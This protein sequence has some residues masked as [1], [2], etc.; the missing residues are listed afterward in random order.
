MPIENSFI[1]ARNL[2]Q[3]GLSFIKDRFYALPFVIAALNV[4]ITYSCVMYLFDTSKHIIYYV[5]GLNLVIF[6][7]FAS[8]IIYHIYMLRYTSRVTPYG[9]RFRYRL[10]LL[11]TIA[12]ILPVLLL[13]VFSSI[14]F[15]NAAK[16]WF[17]TKVERAV[18]NA[19]Y[20]ADAYIQEH[21]HNIRAD[22]F[23]TAVDF[24]KAFKVTQS[25]TGLEKNL[26]TQ[27]LLR[28]LSSI[29]VFDN[30]GKKIIHI[31]ALNDSQKKG[32]IQRLMPAHLIKI[33]RQN[34]F[35]YVDTNTY[36]IHA[37]KR[38]L[39]N[40]K[41]VI[42]N[43]MRRVSDKAVRYDHQTKK[44]VSD[45]KIIKSERHKRELGYALIYI[46]FGM[47]IIILMVK[48]GQ[49]FALQMT[50]PLE[51]LTRTARDIEAGNESARYP[52]PTKVRDEIDRLMIAFNK[53]LDT[54]SHEKK[55]TNAVLK[56]VSTGVICLDH[57]YNVS[58]INQRAVDIFKVC[59]KDLHTLIDL[60][61]DFRDFIS[62]L[63]Q[64]DLPQKS[65]EKARD[66]N[67]L[68][69]LNNGDKVHL[70]L[71]YAIHDSPLKMI[72]YIITI[73]DI[74]ELMR[75]QSTAVWQDIAQRIA[76]EIKNPLTPISLATE[77]IARKWGKEI[78]SSPEKFTQTLEIIQTQVSHILDTA[79]ALSELAK[80]PSPVFEKIN[81]MQILHEVVVL[82]KIRS[83]EIN[84][85]ITDIDA[86]YLSGDKRL[87]SQIMINLLKNATEAM[88]E[89]QSE[90]KKI[91]IDINMN[92]DTLS[93]K[94]RD[95]G[96]GLPEDMPQKTLFTPY[97]T[98]K[99]NGT[100]IG[101]AIVE[102][103]MTDHNGTI[104]LANYYDDA[105]E[106]IVGA[107][108]TLNLPLEI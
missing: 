12:A 90:I 24:S 49:Y 67:K 18:H 1:Y 76:H 31:D 16:G 51:M 40:Q 41:Y 108:V 97:V 74:S 86:I 36:Q 52:S 81:I 21:H 53:M 44:A 69:L 77:H 64:L 61:P 2:S 4:V 47:L 45:Y 29:K 102:K 43:I 82:E 30:D 93:I 72:R 68:Y 78:T 20:V 27:L 8:H 83:P 15:R 26:K 104:Q 96:G 60:T 10:I 19:Q 23:A 11:F 87:L 95:N 5:L 99:E 48:A 34:P 103:V 106:K 54:L 6:L 25:F 38:L 14:A 57:E 75:A 88:H 17:D 94:I 92:K 28:D 80:M 62:L 107:E 58:L 98:T 73:D 91:N 71:R 32:D 7:L 100:G 22:I 37:F 105:L 13:G 3:T 35:I 89:N 39:I 101:L 42:L 50:R 59:Q 70:H 9:S 79:N 84:I 65:S 63:R 46:S 56:G 33:Q 85:Y 66:F 55:L